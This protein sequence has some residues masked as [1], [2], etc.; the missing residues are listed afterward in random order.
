MRTEK[1]H[2]VKI[3][4]AD[5]EALRTHPLAL[6]L[7]LGA[8]CPLARCALQQVHEAPPSPS[9]PL[10]PCIPLHLPVVQALDALRKVR[11][12]QVHEVKVTQLV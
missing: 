7:P 3:M 8:G 6:L 10:L 4:H 2:K 1:V 5:L 11:T 9:N 12:E